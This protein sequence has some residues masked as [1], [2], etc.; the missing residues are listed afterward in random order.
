VQPTGLGDASAEA[1]KDAYQGLKGLSRR[2]FAGRPAA[3]VALE[4]HEK[5]PEAWEAPLREQLRETGADKDPEVLAAAEAL[6]KQ[7]PAGT[8]LGD[9]SVTVNDQGRVGVVGHGNNVV[10]MGDNSPASGG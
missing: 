4:Q 2:V 7:V 10:S 9:V 5:S 3:E 6:L 1:V 8:R